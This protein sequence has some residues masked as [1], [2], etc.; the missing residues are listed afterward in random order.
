M[1]VHDGRDMALLVLFLE[2]FELGY[3]GFVMQFRWAQRLFGDEIERVELFALDGAWCAKLLGAI[4]PCT[5]ERVPRTQTVIEKCERSVFGKRGEPDREFGEFDSGRFE[6]D[7]VDA[8]L[9]DE[10]MKLRFLLVY[11]NSR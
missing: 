10:A 8:V 7:A 9:G 6:I 11:I 3:I 5:H 1:E 4:Q 2:L